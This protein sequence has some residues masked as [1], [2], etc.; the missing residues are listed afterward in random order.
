M[1]PGLSCIGVM[2]CLCLFG[3]LFYLEFYDCSILCLCILTTPICLFSTDS[4]D[5]PSL[6]SDDEGPAVSNS[7]MAPKRTVA[8]VKPS[9]ARL[10]PAKPA[11][12]ASINKHAVSVD[13]D[14]MPG[15]VDSDEDDDAVR[16]KPVKS[17]VAQ[18][19]TAA[20]PIS[21]KPATAKVTA[22]PKVSALPKVSAP[23]A[24]VA[25]TAKS[26]TD[27]EPPPLVEY[28]DKFISFSSFILS[29]DSDIMIHPIYL[30]GLHLFV[31]FLINFTF[32]KQKIFFILQSY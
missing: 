11:Q 18:K 16:S 20:K 15:L 22:P 9:P 30:I 27:E 5:V 23:P 24:K 25:V 17:G 31:V 28:A 12:T 1:L 19:P 21:A 6:V 13:I 8:A 7:K 4:D 32:L 29:Q 10:V 26:P 2:V 14:D 3:R